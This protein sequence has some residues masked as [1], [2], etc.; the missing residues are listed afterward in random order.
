ME[1]NIHEAKTHLS[2]LLQ[3]VVAGEEVTIARAGTPVARLVAVKPEKKT[4]RPMGF[5]RGKIWIAD[6]FDAP[7]PDDLLRQFYGGDVPKPISKRR[8]RK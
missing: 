6:D 1:V 2:R 8:Q 5:D 7:L 3:R 4:P